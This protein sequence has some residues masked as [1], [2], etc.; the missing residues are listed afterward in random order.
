MWTHTARGSSAP[1]EGARGDFAS[2][3]AVVKG[4]VHPR[5]GFPSGSAVKKLHAVQEIQV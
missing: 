2:I 4:G 1:G 3:M 5:G